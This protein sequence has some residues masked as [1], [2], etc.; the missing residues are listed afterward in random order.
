MSITDALKQVIQEH[1]LLEPG[2]QSIAVFSEGSAQELRLLEINREALPTGQV[3]PFVF[4]SDKHFPFP[5]FIA[6]VTPEEWDEICSGHIS[7]PEGWPSTPFQ[8]IHRN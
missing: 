7:L 5:I 4:A 8:I 6:D 3:E 2:L 1:F